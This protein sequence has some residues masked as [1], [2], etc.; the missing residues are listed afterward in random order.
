MLRLHFKGQQA[1]VCEPGAYPNPYPKPYPIFT[2][3]D[4]FLSI[5]R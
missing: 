1:G 5:A 4:I 3:Q 2:P